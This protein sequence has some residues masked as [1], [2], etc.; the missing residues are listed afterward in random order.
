M[1][2][3]KSR[4]IFLSHKKNYGKS[5]GGPY[6]YKLAN[7]EYQWGIGCVKVLNPAEDSGNMQFANCVIPITEAMHNDPQIQM[8]IAAI[9]I[10]ANEAANKKLTKIEIEIFELI[11]GGY[12]VKDIAVKLEESERTIS[13]RIARLKIK[14]GLH[15]MT[16]LANYAHTHGMIYKPDKG[17]KGPASRKH[18]I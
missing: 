13:S 5:F 9:H 3:R 6:R 2:Y 14:L 18:D 8:L 7:G 17:D 11:S 12:Q 16:D 4:S 1:Q 10:K 15:S